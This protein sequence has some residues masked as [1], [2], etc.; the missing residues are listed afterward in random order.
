[1][2]PKFYSKGAFSKSESGS[3]F[4]LHFFSRTPE[5]H[6]LPSRLQTMTWAKSL[7]KERFRHGRVTWGMIRWPYQSEGMNMR[8]F[9]LFVFNKIIW[10]C[11]SMILLQLDDD[12]RSTNREK[13]SA[14][15]I[16]ESYI[17]IHFE[18]A[19]LITVCFFH[20]KLAAQERQI[21]K[22]GAEMKV[23]GDLRCYSCFHGCD[24]NVDSRIYI[25]RYVSTE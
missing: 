16:T 21:Q 23:R 7:E 5:A 1:M 19:H 8:G 4:F 11:W 6:G 24:V 13:I 9:W 25:H 22:I 10:T 3:F 20:K 15:W 17:H 18:T 2:S 14:K 12:T